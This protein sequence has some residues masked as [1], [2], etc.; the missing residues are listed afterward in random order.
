MDKRQSLR[1][2]NKHD[3]RQLLIV[4]FQWDSSQWTTRS[5]GMK[6]YSNLWWISMLRVDCSWNSSADAIP[7]THT[8][9]RRPS[10]WTSFNRTRLQ[11]CSFCFL[12]NLSFISVFER[13]YIVRF[14]HFSTATAFQC[15][16]LIGN[17]NR[18]TVVLRNLCVSAFKSVVS[19]CVYAPLQSQCRSRTF[20]ANWSTVIDFNF[21]VNDSNRNIWRFAGAIVARAC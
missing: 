9:T 1:I 7:R 21:S 18:C 2:V 4:A 14:R 5:T 20:H 3:C 6:H 13:C 19:I 11:A 15:D 8:H 17:D 16:S 10:K 12:C